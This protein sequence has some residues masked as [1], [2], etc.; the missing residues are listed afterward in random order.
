MTDQRGRQVRAATAPASRP[1]LGAAVSAAA[2][3]PRRDGVASSPA[4][5]AAIEGMLAMPSRRDVEV[6]DELHRAARAYLDRARVCVSMAE[7]LMLGRPMAHGIA[8]PDVHPLTDEPL[9]RPTDDGPPAK[10]H[11]MNK[12]V[13]GGVGA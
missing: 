10:G 11:E 6:A 5:V 7:N 4:G 13:R 9:A 2:S 1:D 8:A 12:A 3:L